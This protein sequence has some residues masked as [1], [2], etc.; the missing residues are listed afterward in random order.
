MI[1]T[2]SEGTMDLEEMIP[3]LVVAALGF[4]AWAVT[5]SVGWIAPA[6]VVGGID[7]TVIGLST[8][9]MVVTVVGATVAVIGLLP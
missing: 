1:G 2:P 4:L 9:F 7:R 5:L 6:S 8:C 3:G